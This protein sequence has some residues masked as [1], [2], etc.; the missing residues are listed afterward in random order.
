VPLVFTLGSIAVLDVNRGLCPDPL[1]SLTVLMRFSWFDPGLRPDPLCSLTVLMRF[2]W[3]A[4]GLRPDP[5]CSLTVLM[6]FS[7]FDPGLR[8]DPLCSLMVLMRFSGFDPGLRPDPAG[9]SSARPLHPGAFAP[10]PLGLTGEIL[11]PDPSR[12]K[13]ELH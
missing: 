7:R 2:L 12:M 10:E 4:P 5:L 6:R 13:P 8:P 11:S 3:F 1:C 9:V